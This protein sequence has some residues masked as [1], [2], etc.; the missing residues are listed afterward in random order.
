[1][2]KRTIK[3]TIGFIFGFFA[4]G[5]A[6]VDLIM[7]IMVHKLDPLTII[8]EG[9][10]NMDETPLIG[11]NYKKQTY[12]IDIYKGTIQGYEEGEGVK[13]GECTP[14]EDDS[15]S[16]ETLFKSTPPKPITKWKGY[17]FTSFPLI[18]T[19]LIVIF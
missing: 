8:P 11:L 13:R 4:L 7:Y 1:M 10:Q 17:E 14:D 3:I 19:T 6:I 16:C 18:H 15:H 5:V 9:F 12:D 2:E